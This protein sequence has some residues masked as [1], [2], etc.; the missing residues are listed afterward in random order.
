[1]GVMITGAVLLARAATVS[2]T[3]TGSAIREASA[4]SGERSRT[5]IT[6]VTSTIGGSNLTV[7]VNNTGNTSITDYAKMDF[8]VDYFRTGGPLGTEEALHLDYVTSTPSNRK[9]T[10]MS[11]TPDTYQPG[12]W[13]PGETL[14]LD[15]SLNP[16]KTGDSII[17][18]VWVSTPNGV[19]TMGT[20][21]V[22]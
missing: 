11:L 6:F 10:N 12:I 16:P 19:V 2:D 18:T 14:K 20:F 22:P 15:A 13:D 4:I 17:N 7:D 21:F 8:I 3:L 1:M 5:E 9:W